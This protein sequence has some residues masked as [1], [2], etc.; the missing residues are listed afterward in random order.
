MLN[1]IQETADAWEFLLKNSPDGYKEV[2]R[3]EKQFLL[4]NIPECSKVLDIGCGSGRSLSYLLP[5]NCKVSGIDIDEETINQAKENLKDYESLEVANANS[6]PYSDNIF[7]FVISMLTVV[8][9]PEDQI[10]QIFE[11]IKR[12]TK[13]PILISVF[14]ED[15][16]Q[17]R[18]T[19]YNRYGDQVKEIIGNTV[20]FKGEMEGVVSKGYSKAD[21][22]LLIGNLQL[23]VISIVKYGIAY[24]CVLQK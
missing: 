7:D 1:I 22:D 2:F 13:G 8:N 18:L 5:L 9:F 24:F 21:L 15:S 11:E 3:Y 16:L 12:V 19:V 23:N 14:N 4:E 6:L 20:Y 17:D 10:I